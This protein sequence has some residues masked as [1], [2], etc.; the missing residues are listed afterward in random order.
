MK[1][2]PFQNTAATTHTTNTTK[3]RRR[4]PENCRQGWNRIPVF[5]RVTKNHYSKNVKQNKGGFNDEQII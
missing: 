3:R 4:Q 5:V 2:N 1:K